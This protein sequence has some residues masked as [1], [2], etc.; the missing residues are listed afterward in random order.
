MAIVIAVTGRKGG[1]GKSTITGNLAGELIEAGFNVRVLDTDPQQSL[2]NWGKLGDGV[3]SLISEAVETEH[4]QVFS[5]AVELAKE[6]ADIVLIDT[7]PGFADPALLASLMADVVLLPS[8]P[9][10]LD[11]MAAKDALELVQEAQKSRPDLR[12]RFIPSKL[13]A[14]AG[15]SNDLPQA[16]KDLGAP[17]LPGIHQRT[18]VAEAALSGLT[19]I[20][21]AKSSPARAEFKALSD[22][23]IKELKPKKS[24][25]R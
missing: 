18:V 16:L 25:K 3:L 23:L 22:A 10:P 21:Y 12:I 7:P 14:R 19:V 2:T 24:K 1:I 20:E 11:I 15:L 8:G 17:V 13:I 6:K 5:R 9:S 4:P